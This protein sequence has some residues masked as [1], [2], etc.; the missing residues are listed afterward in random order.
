MAGRLSVACVSFLAV[1]AFLLLFASGT[2]VE[3]AT[4]K[5]GYGSELSCGGLDRHHNPMECDPNGDGVCDATEVLNNCNDALDQDADTLINDGCPIVGN[6]P[7]DQSCINNID[8]DPT[9]DGVTSR[10][11]DGCPAKDSPEVDTECENAIDDDGDTRVNDGCPVQGS[12]PESDECVNAIDDDPGDDGANP[13]INDGCKWYDDS[14]VEDLTYGA[15]GAGLNADLASYFDVWEVT[16]R[17]SMYSLLATAGTPATWQIATD[18]EIPNGAYMGEVVAVST[19]GLFGMPCTT[20]NVVTIPL[21]DCSTDITNTIE[22]SEAESGKNLTYGHEGGLPAG[23][24]KYPEHVLEIVGDAKPR[25]RYYGFTIVIGGMPPTQLNFLM[26]NPGELTGKGAGEPSLADAPRDD[27]TDDLGYINFTVLDNPNI[28]AA[29]DSALDEFCSPLGTTTTLLGVTG[30]EGALDRDIPPVPPK[31]FKGAFWKV[32]SQDGDTFYPE[33]CGNGVDD[34]GDTRID[35]MCGIV[36]VANPGADSGIYD[37]GSHMA[38]GYS[39]SYRDADGD[40]IPN[41]QDECPFDVDDGADT[42]GDHIDDAC[43]P[44]NESCSPTECDEDDDGWRNQADNCPLDSQT[45]QANDD[46]N[47]SIGDECDLVGAGTPPIGQGP[48]T[49]DGEFLNDLEW[50]SMCIAATDTDGDGWCDD[51]ESLLGSDPNDDTSTPEYYGMDWA[52]NTTGEDPPGVAPQSCDNW[53]YYDVNSA[54]PHGGVAP[55]TDDDGDTV[56][57]AAEPSCAGASVYD[58]TNDEDGAGAD[59]CGNTIDDGPDGVADYNDSD[60]WDAIVDA[61]LDGEPDSSDNCPNVANPTQLDTDD[62]GDGDA[63]DTDDDNDA[64]LDTAEW[65]AGTDPK[66]VCD[67]RNFDLKESGE[68]NISDV[69]QF[70]RPLKMR[71]RPCDPPDDYSICEATY[72]SNQ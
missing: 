55:E 65:A 36:R 2:H 50:G 66:N 33:Y 54:N 15:Y 57:N 24:L 59:T 23:C 51:T 30:G 27:L 43:D 7:E 21:Y 68:I 45:S 70:I 53:S 29:S 4:Y 67:P 56:V 47:D 9:D 39:Q 71:D 38:G 26:F 32:G 60:C 10:V 72:R 12:N 49:P 17:Y 41:N 18:K 58:P 34:D 61:D 8:D 64:V 13:T 16:P 20:P 5:M 44:T 46:D 25:A 37:T 28:P 42:D 11:N 19:L 48:D 63:C 3:A 22:W 69:V 62:D 40:T 1:L 14:C 6:L 31:P 52:V 35:E